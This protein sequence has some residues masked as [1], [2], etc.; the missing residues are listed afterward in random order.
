M[1]DSYSSG[2][3]SNQS[4]PSICYTELSLLT[5]T[6]LCRI[7]SAWGF[8][9]KASSSKAFVS[10]LVDSGSK[11]VEIKRSESVT[12]T[13]SLSWKQVYTLNLERNSMLKI[14]ISAKQQFSKKKICGTGALALNILT[15]NLSNAEEVKLHLYPLGFCKVIFQFKGIKE[16]VSD[17]FIPPPLLIPYFGQSIRSICCR[18]GSALP[19]IIFAC[20]SQI[21]KRRYGLKEEGLYRVSGSQSAYQELK[22]CY[23]TGSPVDFEDACVHDLTGLLKMYLRELPEPLITHALHSS[24]MG[25][26]TDKPDVES[27]KKLLMKLP[28]VNRN[29][30]MCFTVL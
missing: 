16:K 7:H 2:I 19:G 22:L 9:L 21:E 8:D 20:I 11:F 25:A 10:F 29:S 28:D 18:E 15:E 24:F 13:E 17:D 23:D 1:Q 14:Q 5:G 27:F 30:L 6:L 26:V 4:A 3:K 12:Y